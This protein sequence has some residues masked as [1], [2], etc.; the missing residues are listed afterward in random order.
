MGF[1]LATMLLLGASTTNADCELRRPERCGNTNELIHD[2]AFQ[3]AIGSFVGPSRT[4]YISRHSLGHQL[5]DALGGPPDEPRPLGKAWLFTACVAHECDNKGAAV[6]E[7]GGRIALLGLVHYNCIRQRDCD[8]DPTLTLFTRDRAKR[9]AYAPGV[10]EWAKAAIAAES[11]S[12]GVVRLKKVETV[13]VPRK[14]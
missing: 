2:R 13:T 14:R 10:I 9:A 8:D 6:V 3:V 11:R 7:R 5:V 12:G 1:L 4:A